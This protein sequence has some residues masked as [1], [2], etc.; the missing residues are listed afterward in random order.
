MTGSDYNFVPEGPWLKVIAFLAI[1]G[2]VAIVVVIGKAIVW[3]IQHVR[4]V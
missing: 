4:F 2:F 3:L 1:T